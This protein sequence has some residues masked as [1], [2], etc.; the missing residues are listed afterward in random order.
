MNCSP[1]RA[2]R[3]AFLLALTTI[4][5]SA[6]PASAGEY[7]VPFCTSHPSGAMD[8]WSYSETTGTTNGLPYFYTGHNC[9][10]NGSGRYR[11]F[12]V[13]AVAAGASSDLTFQAPANTYVSRVHLKQSA[14]P[15]SYG[16]GDA[17]YAEYDGAERTTLAAAVGNQNSSLGEATYALPTIGPRAV[18]IR[19]TMSC[20]TAAY[21]EGTWYGQ[22]GNEYQIR[23]GTVYLTDPTN[24]AVAT[25]TGAGWHTTP[26]DGANTISYEATDTGS[27]I[28]E[29][30][31]YVDGLLVETDT[32]TCTADALVP[33]PLKTSGTMTYDTTR[34]SEG[35]H[36]ISLVALDM[37]GN[38]PPQ[39]ERSLTTT[40]RRT[41]ASSPTAPP[42]TSGGTG[43]SGGAPTTGTPVQG[44]AGTWTGSD[45]SFA[46]Q[47][48]RCD[49]NGQNCVPIAG[50]NGPS[51]TPTS[52]D[53]GHTLVFCVTASNSGGSA[54]RCSAPTAAVVAP[55]QSPGSG[56]T[57][58]S[59]PAPTPVS[60][61][62]GRDGADGANGSGAT[63]RVNLTAVLSSRTTVQKVRYGHRVP[64]TG[65]LLHPDGTPLAGARL[66]V[67]TQ[68]ALPGAAMANEAEV[69]TGP[70][71]RFRWVAPAGPSRTIRFAYRSQ[72]G[73]T[74][75]VDTTDVRLLVMA[76]VTLR[77]APRKVRNKS[78]TV[79]SGR[80][81]GKPVARRGVLVDLQV[82]YRKKW[83]TFAAP[84]T[85]RRGAYRFKYRFTAGAATWKFRARV[86]PG[87]DYP[88][89]LGTSKQ[90]RV[91]V[92]P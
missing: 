53:L 86:R 39:S 52:A 1:L 40:V 37:S 5:L 85:N 41:P 18:R 62:T 42:S 67:Q 2:L 61:S 3:A 20:H 35:E 30:R 77:A 69:V 29:V 10:L 45:L 33:C 44:N 27:G 50:A 21:C 81:L 51:Y 46:Y 9:G 13:N 60:G 63:Q 31:L 16:A 73:E 15:R 88:Y 38:V 92:T 56:A 7:A 87:A 89:E 70:D 11:R 47:W 48:M 26:P 66:T 72:I 55:T 83:R 22:Y 32:S 25:P 64:I 24:P 59:L 79:F 80:V 8:G 75:Y 74:S 34:L 91:K 17:V 36:T 57:A 82:F 71:G 23:G 84:R 58:N 78:A 12:E 19:T 28:R 68:T 43:T 49:Q 6:A 76:G 65:R 4:L 90:R 54:Q 14:T